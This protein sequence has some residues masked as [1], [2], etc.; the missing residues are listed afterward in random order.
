MG[1]IRSIEETIRNKFN[2]AA[3]PALH[4]RVLARVRQA[5]EHSETTPVRRE[6]L[7]GRTIMRS[8][9]TKLAVAAAAVVALAV[10]INEF[11]G[12]TGHGNTAL[13]DMVKTMRQMPWVHY[14]V[15]SLVGG[16]TLGEYW[17][18]F[19]SS[20]QAYRLQGGKLSYRQGREG[21]GYTFDPQKKVIYARQ[22]QDLE[23]EQEPVPDSPS[24][25]LETMLHWLDEEA[26]STT[27][28]TRL[29][30]GQ[31]VEVITAEL[32]R[33]G[34]L[35]RVEVQRDVHENLLVRSRYENCADEGKSLAME[36]DYPTK[37]PES[38]HDLGVPAGTEIVSL[39][40]P[41]EVSEL[42]R[43]LDTLR[44]TRLTR[45]VAVSVPTGTT[46]LPTSFTGRRPERYFTSKDDQVSAIWRNGED[47]CQVRGYLPPEAQGAT[48]ME[49]VSQNPRQVAVS[50]VPV[51]A[52]IFPAGKHP[53]YR[54]QIL[55][56]ARIRS[57]RKWNAVE[58]VGREIFP[59]QIGWPQI[60][61]PQSGAVEW[62]MQPAV[63]ED[64]ENLIL[65]ERRDLTVE[66]WFLNPAKDFLCQKNELARLSDGTIVVSMEILEYAQ[67]PKGQWYP[68]RL[69]K[70]ESRH[71]NGQDIPETV[72]RDIYL[73][74]DPQFPPSL[75]DPESLPSADK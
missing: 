2:V 1:P 52:T 71:V 34:V 9:I 33:E 26:S 23:Q 37:G 54:Y 39:Y 56:G 41:P 3:G 32:T 5:K 68:C 10:A 57:E 22:I 36:C 4:D 38:I 11:G 19:G 40:L 42:I 67:T 35:Y 48:T 61:V 28:Q 45:Y 18:G 62:R 27:R 74:E 44:K 63:G 14:T 69:Q 49:Q 43:K 21:I 46:L 7:I 13:A 16:E 29:L 12:S 25:F 66:R 65:I 15:T 47:R 17:L 59:E 75:F 72:S 31:Q 20:V 53:S 55:N 60:V 8:P 58:A 24:A 50:L 6:P 70:T 51:A 30:D 73:Q 64:G